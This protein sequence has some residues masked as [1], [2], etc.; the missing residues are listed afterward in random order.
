MA[1]TI[2][3]FD[4]RLVED[5]R[6]VKTKDGK[7]LVSL[8]I[9]DNPIGKESKYIATFVSFL[10]GEGLSRIVQDRRLSKGDVVAVAGEFRLREYEKTGGGDKKKKKGGEVGISY[11]IAYPSVFKIIACAADA[12]KDPGRAMPDDNDDDGDDDSPF[13]DD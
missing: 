8:R 6:I 5:P 7:T 12:G 11:E 4:G 2:S 9:A 3:I 10:L 1:N 13:G